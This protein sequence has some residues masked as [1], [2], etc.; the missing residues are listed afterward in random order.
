[1]NR[2]TSDED[3]CLIGAGPSP[4][5]RDNHP[6]ANALLELLEG[7]RIDDLP[8]IDTLVTRHHRIAAGEFLF[9]RGDRFSALYAIRRGS[10][11]TSLP[12]KDGR[13]QITGFQ[14]TGELLGLDGVASDE[15]PVDAIALEDSELCVLHYE[16]FQRV[17]AEHNELQQRLHRAMSREI[18]R[19][20]SILML[21]GSMRSEERLAAFLLNLSERYHALG[22]SARSY[23][24]RMSRED[25]GNFLGL[26]NET[27]SRTLTKLQKEGFITVKGRAVEILN[28]AGLKLLAGYS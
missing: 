16:N 18:V 7:V 25:I 15:H 28:P 1:M 14:M 8:V 17:A 22:Y 6:C 23:L 3:S 12:G 21:L 2:S 10:F 11:K 13:E 4:G 24:L 27:I 9:Q 5:H 19:D 26:K 20:Q